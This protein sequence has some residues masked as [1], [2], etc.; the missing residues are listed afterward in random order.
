MLNQ[1][2]GWLEGG[3]VASF[4][5]MIIDAEMLQM[6]AAWMDGFSVDDSTLALDA[7]NEVGPGGHYFG[8][9]HTLERYQ[10]AF[11]QPLLSDWSNFENWRDRGSRDATQRA[12]TIWKQLLS[13]YEPPDLDPA[14]KEALDDY[15]TRRKIAIDRSAA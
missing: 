15:V 7:V 9:E 5:K 6:M 13:D 14:V 4:E 3:L 10:T 1:G 2:A 8:T 11:Y 12:N